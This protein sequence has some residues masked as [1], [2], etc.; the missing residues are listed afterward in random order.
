M[1]IIIT[2]FIIIISPTVQ[3]QA[4]VHVCSQ[5]LPFSKDMSSEQLAQWLRNHPSLSGADYE[6]D[7]SK[8]IGIM[9]MY[10]CLHYCIMIVIFLFIGAK[11]SA[12]VFLDLN[13]SMLTQL[14]GIT[15]LGFQLAIMSIIKDMVSS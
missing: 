12:H 6:E 11:I 8:L 7:I 9:F 10:K 2:F 15:S 4:D 1:Q 3:T 13:E 14:F 5:P